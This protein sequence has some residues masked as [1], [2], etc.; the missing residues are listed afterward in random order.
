M[1][2]GLRRD[3]ETDDEVPRDIASCVSLDSFPSRTHPRKSAQR[4]TTT[5]SRKPGQFFQDLTPVQNDNTADDEED[6]LVVEKYRNLLQGWAEREKQTTA[7]AASM[8]DF[9]DIDEDMES[10]RTPNRK[11]GVDRSVSGCSVQS[12]LSELMAMSIITAGT[13]DD[14]FS[15]GKSGHME[16]LVFD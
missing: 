4:E 5:N 3:R 14:V 15:L 11:R 12:T 16:V 10:V 8:G 1:N 13:E 7:A 2:T 6:V 9:S